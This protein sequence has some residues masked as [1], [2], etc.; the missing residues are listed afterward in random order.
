MVPIRQRRPDVPAELEA[1]VNKA[2]AH[3]RDERYPDCRSFHQ[4]LERFVMTSGR[5]PVGTFEIAKL[6]SELQAQPV[7]GP[8]TGIR[9]V[10]TPAA[11]RGTT[12]PGPDRRQTTPP[13]PAGVAEA[14][15][16]K[17]TGTDGGGQSPLLL[18]GNLMVS[19]LL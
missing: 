17:A 13:Q 4:D 2:L 6:I 11:P 16:L 7:G 19:A 3:D 1:I 5:E 9:G 15:S 10:A 12:T 8:G 18:T 14:A